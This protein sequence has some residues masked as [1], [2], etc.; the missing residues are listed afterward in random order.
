MIDQ[1]PSKK[2]IH[3]KVVAE[4]GRL[5]TLAAPTEFHHMLQDLHNRSTLLRCYSQNIDGLERKVGFE[6]DSTF[7]AS[8]RCI[9]LH[10][11][12]HF[13]K[14]TSCKSTHLFQDYYHDLASGC[15]PLCHLCQQKEN[16]RLAAGHRHRRPGQLRPDIILYGEEHDQGEDIANVCNKDL[17]LGLLLV[18]GTSL[19]VPG[20]ARLIKQFSKK[21]HSNSLQH[22]IY[23]DINPPSKKWHEVF[24]VFIEG[25][26]QIFA[27]TLRQSILA[28]SSSLT[29]Q[30][31]S[32]ESNQNLQGYLVNIEERQDFRPSW[33]WL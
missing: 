14:C 33:N 13:L 19:K 2:E 7:G 10:G 26:C 24:D 23:L 15:F 1:D 5:S 12:L 30:Q 21:L 18:V 29:S 20:T 11:S 17:K 6:M 3:S 28:P 22:S 8:N 25:D 32:D 4:L 16:G 31:Q 27:Q 9:P